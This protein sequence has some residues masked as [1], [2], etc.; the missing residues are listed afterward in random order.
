MSP[1]LGGSAVGLPVLV[2][3]SD[4][5]GWR[6]PVLSDV[7]KPRQALLTLQV[8]SPQPLHPA[9]PHRPLSLHLVWVSSEPRGG[10][11]EPGEATSEQRGSGSGTVRTSVLGAGPSLASWG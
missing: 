9:T 4:Q 1:G 6:G 3:L 11:W 8:D 5:Q 2:S 7:P 10:G